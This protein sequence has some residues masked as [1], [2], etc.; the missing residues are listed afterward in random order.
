MA[1]KSNTPSPLI[2]QVSR[3]APTVSE[4][5]HSKHAR[6]TSAITSHDVVNGYGFAF[7]FH[8]RL[9]LF[10]EQC[11]QCGET[12]FS[13]PILDCDGHKMER[14]YMQIADAE[15]SSLEKALVKLEAA[16]DMG[17]RQRERRAA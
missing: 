2:Q 9:E 7:T 14:R 8:L 11:N 4:L 16:L 1:K 13:A 10:I 15:G 17:N 12:Q 3:F 5:I 6:L